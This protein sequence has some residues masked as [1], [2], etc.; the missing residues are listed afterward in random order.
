MHGN[1]WEWC[2]EWHGEDYYSTGPRSDPT[3]PIRTPRVSR[4][5]SWGSPVDLARPLGSSSVTPSEAYAC[6]GLRVLVELSAS[7]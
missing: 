5:G 4:G 7:K 3:G 1:V 2:A 6:N